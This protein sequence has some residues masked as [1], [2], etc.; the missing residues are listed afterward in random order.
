MTSNRRGITLVQL[1]IVMSVMSVV[2][3]FVTFTLLQMFQLESRSSHAYAERMGQMR[4]AE[5]YRRDVHRAEQVAFGAEKTGRS[6]ILTLTRR[7]GTRTVYLAGKGQVTRTAK[8][9][10]GSVQRDVYRLA[11]GEIHFARVDGWDAVELAYTQHA[12]V[13]PIE[14]EVPV[15]LRTWRVQAVPGRDYRWDDHADPAEAER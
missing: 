10:A 14:G 1:L 6:R 8:P 13:V 11:A 5:D 7:D 15:V 3:T 9:P 2:L 4:L 12:R